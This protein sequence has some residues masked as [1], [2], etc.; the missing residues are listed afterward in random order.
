MLSIFLYYLL[1][2]Y[3]AGLLLALLI[4]VSV[5]LQQKRLSLLRRGSLHPAMRL[6]KSHPGRLL[7]QFGETPPLSPLELRLI[8]V[9]TRRQ[10]LQLHLTKINPGKPQIW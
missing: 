2:L 5:V 4:A 8:Q 1:Y 10:E 7:K 3:L 6:R 9:R